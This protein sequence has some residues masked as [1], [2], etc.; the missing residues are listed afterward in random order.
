MDAF[1]A[2]ADPKLQ[3]FNTSV[4]NIGSANLDTYAKAED[5]FL[6]SQ[7]LK[8]AVEGIQALLAPGVALDTGATTTFWNR[9][10]SAAVANGAPAEIIGSGQTNAQKLAALSSL[11]EGTGISP[12]SLS[13]ENSKDAIAAVVDVLGRNIR[14]AEDQYARAKRSLYPTATPVINNA[15][16]PVSSA[17]ATTPT[18]P[19]APGAPVVQ[20]ASGVKVHPRSTPQNPIVTAPSFEAAVN[21]PKVVNGTT[22][23]YYDANGNLRSQ[24]VNRRR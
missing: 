11:L 16:N 14:T 9:L 4:A 20:R 13:V 3:A 8:A 2:V 15:L 19:A 21:D 22:V 18:S 1:R 23:Y 10:A 12:A 17:P 6:R 5:L 7:P 24:K